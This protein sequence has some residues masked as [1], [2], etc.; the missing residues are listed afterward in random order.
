MLRKPEAIK[1][2]R[3]KLRKLVNLAR[4]GRIPK[5]KVYEHYQTWRSCADKGNNHRMV[6][7]M[8]QYFKQLMEENK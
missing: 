5:G 4:T 1:A 6:M 2:E 3:K 8:D 7:R